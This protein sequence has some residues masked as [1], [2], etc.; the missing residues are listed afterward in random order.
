MLKRMKKKTLITWRK[1]YMYFY[2]VQYAFLWARGSASRSIGGRQSRPRAQL[3]ATPSCWWSS[4]WRQSLCA[5]TRKE[6][7]ISW[8]SYCGQN[9]CLAR[10][11]RLNTGI[12][13]LGVIYTA[14]GDKGYAGEQLSFL[15]VWLYLVWVEEE[16]ASQWC[17][18]EGRVLDGGERCCLCILCDCPVPACPSPTRPVNRHVCLASVLRGGC[19]W[20]SLRV[21]VWFSGILCG[22]RPVLG[23]LLIK[24][25][26]CA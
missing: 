15:P 3:T 22:L 18:G 1:H 10:H 16:C 8:W 11:K 25:G 4:W 21:C 13:M 20:Q 19:S 17:D 6:E 2:T 7:T 9:K 5:T 14:S 24:A 23:L 26:G 12:N